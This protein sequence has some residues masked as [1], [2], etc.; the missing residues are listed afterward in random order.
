LVQPSEV[1]QTLYWYLPDRSHE[2][3]FCLDA[4]PYITPP[5]PRWHEFLKSKFQFLRRPI[6]FEETEIW[7][8]YYKVEPDQLDL[9][10]D[11]AVW[12]RE[13]DGFY[14]PH[15]RATRLLHDVHIGP[16]LDRFNQGQGRPYIEYRTHRISSYRS[17]SR[18]RASDMLALSLLQA[19]LIDRK[20]PIRIEQWEEQTTTGH[21][22]LPVA[23]REDGGKWL[24]FS[25]QKYD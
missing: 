3:M 13:F 23:E 5:P 9:P 2:P 22:G 25:Q 16:N 6:T 8:R 1:R 10:M 18:Y 20:L 14:G 7:R 12:Q 4:S 21:L 19:R 11:A 15:G 17:R 24:W